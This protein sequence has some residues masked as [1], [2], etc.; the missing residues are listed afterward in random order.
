[1]LGGV[2][3]VYQPTCYVPY[4]GSLAY[5]PYDGN[6]ARAV[7]NVL[8]QQWAVAGRQGAATAALYTPISN[9]QIRATL[10]APWLD[11]GP[12][13][14]N[15]LYLISFVQDGKPWTG[16]IGSAVANTS[17]RRL[18]VGLVLLVHRHAGRRRPGGAHRPARVVGELA[19][20]LPAGERRAR[21]PPRARARARAAAAPTQPGQTVPNAA[22]GRL[23][24]FSPH[25]SKHKRPDFRRLVKG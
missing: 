2:A 5:Q 13:Q 20:L 11:L 22:G 17:P 9:V 1:M 12:G 10:A 19:E 3:L 8:P 4:D 16:V 15:A 24:R 18:R 6:P 7:T 23:G 14:P 21:G 25:K